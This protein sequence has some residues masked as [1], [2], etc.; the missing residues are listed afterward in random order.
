LTAYGATLQYR[1]T[2]GEAQRRIQRT[3]EIANDGYKAGSS[4][5]LDL[6]TTE[7]SLVAINAQVASSD[8]E[9]VGT[10][11]DLFKALGGGWETPPS[12]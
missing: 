1:Q 10:Q 12:R 7:Q 2:L 6:L 3:F 8:A 4:S 9:L 5:Y 11:I